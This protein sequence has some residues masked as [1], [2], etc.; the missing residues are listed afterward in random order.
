MAPR[1]QWAIAS[2]RRLTLLAIAIVLGLPPVSTDAVASCRRHDC[3]NDAVPNGSNAEPILGDERMVWDGPPEWAWR[4][5]PPPEEFGPCAPPDELRCY[6]IATW[7]DLEIQ[8]RNCESTTWT[9]SQWSYFPP[10][11]FFDPYRSGPFKFPRL[12]ETLRFVVRACEG[13]TCGEWGP[14]A[15]DGS[16]D[17]VEFVGAEY[18]CVEMRDGERC[19]RP[20]A[21]GG[22][23]ALPG[24]PDC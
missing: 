12:G 2:M 3:S 21:F 4:S 19:E 1:L 24:L 7:P 8:A 20:C 23:T 6:E 11:P 16:Q 15:G 22:S 14:R 10:T 13:P 9:G 18:V 5:C 17:W